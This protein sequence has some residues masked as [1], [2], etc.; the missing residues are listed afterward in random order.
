[1]D[2][3]TKNSWLGRLVTK[4]YNDSEEAIGEAIEEA[5]DDDDEEEEEEEED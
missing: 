4:K 1:M 2:L 3:K 5:M